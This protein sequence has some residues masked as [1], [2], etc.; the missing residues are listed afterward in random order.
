MNLLRLIP[1][2]GV[3]TCQ[4]DQYDLFRECPL[5]LIVTPLVLTVSVILMM[6][7]WYRIHLYNKVFIQCA[8]SQ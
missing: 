2:L 4:L 1:L 8:R 3:V 7:L 5:V 6:R